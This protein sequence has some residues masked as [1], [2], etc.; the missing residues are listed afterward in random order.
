MQV[1]SG[2]TSPQRTG[3]DPVFTLTAVMQRRGPFRSS[4]EEVWNQVAQVTRRVSPTHPPTHISLSLSLAIPPYSSIHLV[5]R[6]PQTVTRLSAATMYP[7][8]LCHADGPLPSLPDGPG[9]HAE[10]ASWEAVADSALRGHVTPE[11]GNG[12]VIQGP[13]F[14]RGLPVPPFRSDLIRGGSD[15]RPSWWYIGE[16]ILRDVGPLPPSAG[17]WR[18]CA[19]GTLG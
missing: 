19:F 17:T 5:A 14:V 7:L 10:Y 4:A 3:P 9:R 1:P 11:E 2:Q 8:Q 6:P 12:C 18:W 16:L 13:Q 15:S